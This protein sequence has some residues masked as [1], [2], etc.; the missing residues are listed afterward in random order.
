[1]FKKDSNKPSSQDRRFP[2]SFRVISLA[3]VAI[4]LG[5]FYLQFAWS[6][7]QKAAESE[8]LRLAQSIESLLHVEHIEMLALDDPTASE[9][10]LVEQS[11]VHLVEATDSIYYAYILRQQGEDIA[12]IADSSSADSDTSN[13]I[14]RH[15]EETTEVNL[16]PFETG[17][18]VLAESISTRCGDWMR[19]LV[20]IYDLKDENV[21]AVLG[22]S[23]SASEW[24]ANLWGRMIP[25]FVVAACLAALVF[26]LF[27]LLR[28][29][30][31]HKI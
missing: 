21:I 30:T 11:L 16:L 6:R 28:Q 20:P 12:I 24:Q 18:S 13:P 15:C 19:A 3:L 9:G 22:L 7:Y 8:A 31:E 27:N 4:M 1:M 25:D 5:G 14:A 23:Y 2:F 26:T 17:Q 29:K 10:H